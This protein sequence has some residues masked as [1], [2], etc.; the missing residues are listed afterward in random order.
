MVIML[1]VLM[2]FMMDV[3]PVIAVLKCVLVLVVVNS[4]VDGGG[5]MPDQWGS[6]G[7]RDGLFIVM[8][9]C[10]VAYCPHLL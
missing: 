8:V 9:A 6:R 5:I 7:K 1:V 4:A 2:V 3:K 10:Q